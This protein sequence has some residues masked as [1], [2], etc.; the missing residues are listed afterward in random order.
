MRQLFILSILTTLLL[1]GCTKNITD[2]NNDPKKAVVVPAASLFVNGM[3]ALSDNYINTGGGTAPFRFFAQTWTQNTYTTEARYILSAYNAPDNW[4]AAMYGAVLNNLTQAKKLFVLGAPDAATL[5][6]DLI[7]TDI[8]Q[9]YAYNLLVTTYGNIPY[10][11]AENDLVPFPKY[12]DAKTVY[13]DLLTRLDTCIAGLNTA[14]GAMGNADQIYKGNVTKW[15]KF[16]ATLKLKMAMLLADTDPGT[17]GKKAQ[18]AVTAGVFTA[19]ADNAL[20]TYMASPTGNTNPIWQALVNSGRHDNCPT[21]IMMD[22]MKKWNDPRIPLYFTKD[23][24]GSGLYLGGVPGAGNS[25]FSLS[26]FSDAWSSPTRP[27]DLL[28]YAEAEFLQAEAIE[29]GFAVGGTAEQ[30]YNSG[31]TAAIQY[32]GGSAGDATTYLAQPSVAY[33]TANGDYKQKIGFQKWIALADRGWDAWTEIRRLKQPNLD[34][35]NPP[36]GASGAMPVRFY[37]PTTEQ[38]SN[39][40]NWAAAVKAMSGGATDVVTTKLFWMP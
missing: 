7:I 6:N 13:A 21:N 30:H 32:W 16:A 39:P 33:L 8:L 1:A 24:G 4:W 5:K 9:I 27:S 36:V 2:F 10:S 11:Q 28:D 22:T 23:L 18:E 12:D 38:S 19:N 35:I 17:A 37:Y 15:K 25:Y 3:K 26:T 29:R 31:V 34:L 40:V 14:A 20:L